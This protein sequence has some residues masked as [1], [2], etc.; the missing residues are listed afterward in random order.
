MLIHGWLYVV[1]LVFD[2]TVHIVSLI[3][4][5]NTDQSSLISEFTEYLDTK[6]D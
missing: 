4:Y 3:F 2:G 1:E 5:L 6:V